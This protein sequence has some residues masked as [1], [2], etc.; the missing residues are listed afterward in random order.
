MAS[1]L[2]YLELA[3]QRIFFFKESGA[4]LAA[5][6]VFIFLS[7]QIPDKLFHFRSIESMLILLTQKGIIAVAMTLL[8][9]SREIDISVGAVYAF[10]ST[11]YASLIAHYGVN[12]W[13]ALILALLV[14]LP[15]GFFHGIV[16]TKL[17]VPSL[18]V[19]L[20]TFMMWRGI[21]LGIW[22]ASPV[23]Y[24]E[25][26]T[27][28]TILGGTFLGRAGFNFSFIWLIILIIIGWVILEK[29]SFGNKI[30]ATG[31][32]TIA[33]KEMGVDTDKT[34]ILL[35]MFTSFAAG[36]SGIIQFGHLRLVAAIAGEG[37]ELETIGATVIGGTS[38]FGGVGTVIGSIIGGFLMAEI[39][40]GIILMG[41]SSYWYRA[42]VGAVLIV[43]ISM[44]L[45][46]KRR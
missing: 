29:T 26:S 38:L 1:P 2:F 23:S 15:I 4:L 20:A 28:L 42:I 21:V 22:G 9:I 37:L 33:A 41:I 34:K 31:G 10:I 5:L 12:E 43:A 3:R 14:S 6:A 16:T 36:L 19:T 25:E 24:G 8:I 30:Y 46:V 17:R 11:L 13:V 39:Q 7:I 44:N 18:V 45:L 35:F 27:A 40:I 32:N